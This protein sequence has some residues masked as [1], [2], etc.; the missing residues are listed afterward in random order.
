MKNLLFILISITL[1]ISCTSSRKLIEKGDYDR[2]INKLVQ[3]LAGKKSKSTED[4]KYLELA[5]R[6]AQNEDL[7][8]EKDLLTLNSESKW[9][10]IYNIYKK[11]DARQNRIEPLLPLNSNEGYLGR[12]DFI[13]TTN[14]KTESRE[15]TVEFYYNSAKQLIEDSKKNNN[16]L[17]A[18]KAVD[19]FNKIDNLVSSYRDVK[20]LREIA[21][22]LGT[23][24]IFFTMVNNTAKI[25]PLQL[26][27]DLVSMSVSDLNTYWKQYDMKKNTNRVYDYNIFMNLQNLEFSPEREKS[28]IIEDVWEEIV[29]EERKDKNGK[30]LKDSTGKIVYTERT[31]VHKSIIEETVQS[32]TAI[33]GGKL[34]WFKVDTKNLEDS[35]PINV[36]INFINRFGRLI[37]GNRDHISKENKDML[38]GGPTRFPSNENL[39]L[40]AG[41]KL[42]DIVKNFIKRR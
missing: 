14:R 23:E 32:K 29:K 5:F 25:I 2:A 37:E 24:Y 20:N 7:A 26:E 12:F 34:E 8:E 9:E 22:E 40:D 30:V 35:E 39:T 31:R 3:G 36:E 19:I 33:L 27:E 6:K 21:H 17:D 11:I 18:R 41:E 1:I 4:I 15:K 10:K 16:K 42:K 38:K 28:R 13:N